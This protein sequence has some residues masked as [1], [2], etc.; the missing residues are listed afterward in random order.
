MNCPD[1][2]PFFLAVWYMLATSIVVALGWF[3]GGRWLRW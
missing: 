1:D 3:A 2:S